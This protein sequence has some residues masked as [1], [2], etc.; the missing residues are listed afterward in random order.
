MEMVNQ[1]RTTGILLIPGILEQV[2]EA[3]RRNNLTLT[4]VIVDG[5]K[6]L[7]NAFYA[8]VVITTIS[9]VGAASADKDS[10]NTRTFC[11]TFACIGASMS[12]A[13][14]RGIF[15]TVTT[16]GIKMRSGRALGLLA[17]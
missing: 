7:R 5:T 9:S 12:L 1:V 15:E 11:L 10:E 4:A 16:F 8:G 14:V 3:A 17:E 2:E 6:L 13:A